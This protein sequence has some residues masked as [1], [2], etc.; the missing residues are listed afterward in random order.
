M[1]RAKGI[2]TLIEAFDSVLDRVPGAELVIVGPRDTVDHGMT[3][4]LEQG[5]QRLSTRGTVRQL[6]HLDFGPALFQQ[7]ADAD[8]L[9]LPSRS[10]G[11]PRVLVEARAFGCPVIGTR[12]G[13]I[14]TSITDGV[15]GLLIPPNDARGAGQFDR[16]RGADAELRRQLVEGGLTLRVPRRSS[17][18]CA[19]WPTKSKCCW[20]GAHARC[21]RSQS[22]PPAGAATIGGHGLSRSQE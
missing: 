15:D 19:R 14:P 16:A 20:T 13:G 12:V 6:G 7:Y 17:R 10:E 11:T 8:V 2:D 9:A 22:P 21:A 18:S 3:E 1:R 4:F 5:L